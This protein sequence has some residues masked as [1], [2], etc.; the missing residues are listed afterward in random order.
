MKRAMILIVMVIILSTSTL[1]A[2]GEFLFS[3]IGLGLDT[4]STIKHGKTEVILSDSGSSVSIGGT[5]VRKL[6]K[7]FEEH[8]FASLNYEDR[9]ELS[10]RLSVSI[11]WPVFKNLLVGFGSGSALQHDT[12]GS[13]TGIVLDSVTGGAVGVGLGLFIVDAIF[14]APL[15]GY[16]GSNPNDDELLQLS[17]DLMMYGAIGFGVGRVIQAM[18]PLVYGP[19]YNKVVRTHLGINK[20]KSDAY[21]VN[22][23][24]APILGEGGALHWQVAARIPLQ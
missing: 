10:E 5:G 21:G 19:R 6:K 12:L 14:L 8:D 22:L 15:R 24:F 17:L 16:S 20:D 9:L 2:A 11:T 1:F 4:A 23:G 13:I 18:L 3:I 7:T